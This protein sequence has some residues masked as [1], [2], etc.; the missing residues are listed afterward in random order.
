MKNPPVVC[1]VFICCSLQLFMAAATM[2]M[3]ENG[4]DE[5]ELSVKTSAMTK[6]SDATTPAATVEYYKNT[7]IPKNYTKTITIGYL[8]SLRGETQG[9]AISGALTR[10][11]TQVR[12]EL[13]TMMML[14]KR[15]F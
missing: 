12:I 10:A 7:T 15:F 9:L 2:A 13:M 14:R 4:G 6:S 11:L 8:S 5:N 3:V 1:V